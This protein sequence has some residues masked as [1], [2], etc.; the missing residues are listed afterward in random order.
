M[1]AVRTGLDESA[2]HLSNKKKKRDA[3]DAVTERKALHMQGLCLFAGFQELNGI[4]GAVIA[5]DREVQVRLHRCL[6]ACG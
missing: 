3:V 5:V 4:D 1:A 6:N 2:R